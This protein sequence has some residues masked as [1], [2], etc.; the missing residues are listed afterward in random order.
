MTPTQRQQLL[1]SGH[2]YLILDEKKQRYNIDDKGRAKVP[3]TPYYVL[4]L[5]TMTISKIDPLIIKK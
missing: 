5:E 3:N 4:D 2:R 1:S